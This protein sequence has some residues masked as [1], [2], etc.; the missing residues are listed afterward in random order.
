[1][2][3]LLIATTMVFAVATTVLATADGP[4]FY[5]VRD[6]PEGEVLALHAE[7]DQAADVL[8]TVP[9]DGDG[10]RNL[11]CQGR[12]SYSEWEAATEAERD[13]AAE[14]VWCRVEYDGVIGWARGRFLAE[15]S[16]PSAQ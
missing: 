5:K 13:A 1:M 14:R 8:A 7:P 11:L 15:G 2:R 3:V 12:L 6:L 10:L 4:D 16:A 9:H